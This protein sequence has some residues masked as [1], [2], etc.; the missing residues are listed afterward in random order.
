[1]GPNYRSQYGT[2]TVSRGNWSTTLHP[3]KRVYRME[4]NP[5]TEAG[6]STNLWRDVYVALGEPLDQGAWAV[7]LYHKPLVVWIW[8]GALIMSIGGFLSILDKRYRIRRG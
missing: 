7:R 8:F 4:S 3:E 6:I 5:M 1:M 2:I